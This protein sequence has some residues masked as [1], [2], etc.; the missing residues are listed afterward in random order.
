ML[1][2]FNSK[3]YENWYTFAEVIMKVKVAYLSSETL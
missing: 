2:E 3:N 1:S